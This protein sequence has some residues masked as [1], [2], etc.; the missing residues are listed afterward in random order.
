MKRLALS[1]LFL[2]GCVQTTGGRLV[3]FSA[4]A[5]GDPAVVSGGPLS[6]T[7]P[8]GFDVTLTRAQLFA[9]AVYLSQQNPQSYTLETSCIQ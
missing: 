7:T 4:Q 6:F 3:E 2:S 5:S 8:A 9:G 1:L